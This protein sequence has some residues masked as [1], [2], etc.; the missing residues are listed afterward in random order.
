MATNHALVI[1]ASGLIG[2]SVVNQLLQ[3]Y[4]ATTP[5]RKITACVNRPLDINDS[6]WPLTPK[7]GPELQLVSGI[8]LLCED[9]AFEQVLKDKLS[10]AEGITHVFYFAFKEEKDVEKEVE[11]NVGMMRRVVRAVK[12]LSRDFK[13][14]VYPGGTRGYGIYRPDGIF[15]PPLT[16]DLAD[17][18]PPDY[19]KTVAYPHYRNMLR[20]ESAQQSWTWCELCPDIIVGFTPNG[21][22]YSL[23]GHWAIYLYAWK[24][25][26]G[27]GSEVPY[28]GV[29]AG[30]RSLFTET[31]ATTL[32][33][34]AIHASQHPESF[35]ERIFNVSDSDIPASMSERWPQI[36]SWFGLKG[37]APSQTASPSD[38]KPSEF[39][40]KHQ[41]EL[42]AAGVKCVDIWNAGQ[43]DSVGY[44]LTFDR[45]LSLSRLR[46]A[47]FNEKVKPEEGWWNAFESFR[48][49]GMIK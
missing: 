12:N 45:H 21:S 33:R 35:R 17:Q 7:D 15:T 31:S 37:V 20:H 43:L 13:F 6:Y 8:N 18:L 3:P 19:L 38:Q 23:A 1:G 29:E 27:E 44:W 39:I 34:V 32:A 49:A 24:L 40:A 30:Y 25:V 10:H 2:W 47:G 16:E 46:S 41:K 26:H 11:V 9:E 42:E 28:P 22:G 4:P 14:F 5:F 48:K 36:A